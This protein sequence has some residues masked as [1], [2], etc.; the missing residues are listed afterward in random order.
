MMTIKGSGEVEERTRQDNTSSQ[1]K[2]IR[3]KTKPKKTRPEKTTPDKTRQDHPKEGKTIRQPLQFN[4]CKALPPTSSPSLCFLI[5]ATT[6][7][8]SSP[9]PISFP[10]CDSPNFNYFVHI[11]CVFCYFFVFS[12]E[13]VSFIICVTSID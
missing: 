9:T 7:F 2:T 8:S 6:L 13:I 5:L 1:Y 12:Y 3:E 11:Y 10:D 4:G